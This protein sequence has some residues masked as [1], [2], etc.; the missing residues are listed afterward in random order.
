MIYLMG[1]FNIDILQYAVNDIAQSTVNALYSN[2]YIPLIHRPTR[3]T[4]SSATLLDNIFTNQFDMSIVSGLLYCD[5]SDHLPVFQI[6][7][8]QHPITS[9]KNEETI[10]AH[11]S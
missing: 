5:I 10:Q 3:V 2:F 11:F 4:R 8:L 7:T 9:T 6:T 1:D